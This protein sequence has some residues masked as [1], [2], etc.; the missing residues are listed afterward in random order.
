MNEGEQTWC[1][2]VK[3]GVAFVF[4]AGIGIAMFVGAILVIGECLDGVSRYQS[5]H[6]QCLK[7]ATNGYEIKRCN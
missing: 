4:V 1:E 7:Q 5:E 2:R 3:V 6:D